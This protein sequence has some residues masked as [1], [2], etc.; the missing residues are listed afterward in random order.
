MGEPQRADRMIEFGAATE[1]ATAA[2][3]LE[4]ATSPVEAP[5]G[6]GSPIC[7]HSALK[8]SS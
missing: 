7:P 6:D 5:P 3:V 1:E 4:S 8:S 2:R